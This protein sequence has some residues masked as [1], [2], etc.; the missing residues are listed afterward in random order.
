MRRWFFA[1]RSVQ[2]QPVDAQKHEQATCDVSSQRAHRPRLLPP[3]LWPVNAR[4][5]QK[6]RVAIRLHPPRRVIGTA[7]AV[8]HARSGAV[9]IGRA[10]G[11]CV[12]CIALPYASCHDVTIGVAPH[13]VVESISFRATLATKATVEFAGPLQR[14]AKHHRAKVNSAFWRWF[15]TWLSE[16]FSHFNICRLCPR[17][18]KPLVLIQ[19]EVHEPGARHQFHNITTAAPQRSSTMSLTNYGIFKKSNLAFFYS[20]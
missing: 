2:H 11:W 10:L 1:R 6:T 16:N 5:G 8:G 18:I 20:R 4:S 9:G 3:W 12:H 14:F 13:V 15:G 19:G 17:V 7:S